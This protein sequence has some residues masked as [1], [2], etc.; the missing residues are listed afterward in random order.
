MYQ[1]TELIGNLGADP[2]VRYTQDGKA[3]AN[4]SIATS[5]TWKDKQTGERKE[6][7]EWHRVVF[8]APLAEIVGEYLKKGSKVFVAGQNRTRKWQDK[9]GQDRWTTEIHGR[10]MKMLDSKSSGAPGNRANGEGGFRDPKGAAPDP[11]D[12]DDEDIPF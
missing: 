12:F 7:T 2:E 4:C 9:D 10:E 3:I 8:F 5:E 11:N 1:R 6:R